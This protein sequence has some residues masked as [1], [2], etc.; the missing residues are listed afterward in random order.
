VVPLWVTDQ[1]SHFKN[2]AMA[3]IARQLGTQYHFTTAY[4]PWANGSVEVLNRQ[5]K[6]CVHAL[7]SERQLHPTEWS[8]VLPA[9][10][11][12]LN[13][14]PS[15]RLAG[16]APITAFTCLPAQSPLRVFF[17]SRPHDYATMTLEAIAAEVSTY[18]TDLSVSLA[19]MHREFARTSAAGRAAARASSA[20]RATPPKFDLGDFVLVG[21]ITAHP[22]KLS[23]AS[24][25]PMRIVRV[26]SDWIFE[27]ETLVPPLERSLHHA[28][29]LRLYHD[30]SLNVT[31]GLRSYAR[32]TAGGHM[33]RSFGGVRRAA[34]RHEVLVHW[35][36]LDDAESSWEPLDTLYEDVSILVT[37]YRQ[38]AVD[39]EAATAVLAHL[40]RFEGPSRRRASSHRRGIPSA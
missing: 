1:G 20:C 13:H 3:L 12:A 7:L 40:R 6:R 30:A 28:T 17:T 32:Y 31:E 35:L 36:G 29:R 39:D 34:G 23:V 2:E 14:Q 25:G 26:V 15:P 38:D 18:I 22:P 37:R 16:V 21:T 9:V 4:T 10:V 8:L 5:L 19:S 11:T 33:V 27:V 24:R